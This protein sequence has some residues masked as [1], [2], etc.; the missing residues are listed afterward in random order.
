MSTK[1]AQV[2]ADFTTQLTTQLA[3]GGTTASLAS[4]TDDDGN[5]LP[6]GIYFFTIDGGNSQKEHIVCSLSGLDLT[7][8]SSVSRQGV[9]ASGAARLHRV[10]A[11]V[12]ITDFAHLL[13]V[14]N[15]LTGATNLDATHPLSYDGTA[16]INSANQLATKAYVDGVAIAGAPDASTTVKGVTKLDT[17]PA[18][19]TAPIAVGVNSAKLTTMSGNA[20]DGSTYKIV[21]TGSVATTGAS[22]VLQLT[23]GG[24]VTTSTL[25]V[26]TGNNQIVQL[27]SS[28]KLPAVDGSLLTNVGTYKSGTTTKDASDASAVQ[29]IAHSLGKT[30][31]FI[32]IR[33]IAIQVETNDH[34]IREAN[35]TYNGTT[36]ASSSVYAQTATAGRAVIA[37]TFT[38]NLTQSGLADTQ[39]GVVT[40]DGTNII[41][42]WTKTN[43]PTGTYTLL[44]EAW[45]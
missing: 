37:T 19:A 26:G 32:R 38:L 7:A 18:S 42:T 17:A 10:G 43:S 45:G 9:E 13:F 40:F 41:I 36:Q 16:T 28:A 12:S 20:L 29:N 30:P 6:S 21:D 2:I 15:L 44:W 4:A 35:T 24:K 34:L 8:I 31:K 14:V 3:I 33:A 27:D 11:T 23:A 5:A 22:K 39:T 1:L 25:D